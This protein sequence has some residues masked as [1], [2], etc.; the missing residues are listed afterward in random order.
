MITRDEYKTIRQERHL[1]VLD[2]NILLELYRQPANVSRDIIA[3]FQKIADKVYIPHRVYEEYLENRQKICGDE[4]KK[5]KIMKHELDDS[6]S[7]FKESI[8]KKTNENR[9]HNYSGI[10]KLQGDIERKLDEIKETIVAYD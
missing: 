6:T 1:I 4:Q 2:T 7:R 10:T 3:G 8:R 5:Y 9:K